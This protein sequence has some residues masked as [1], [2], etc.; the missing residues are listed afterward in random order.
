MKSF[1]FLLLAGSVRLSSTE[2]GYFWHL[3]DLHLDPNYTVTSDPRKVC[4]SAGDQLVTDAGQWGNYLCDSPRVLINS[5]IY[6]MKSILPKPDFILWTGDDTPHVPNEQLGEEAVL[7]I[8][9]WLTNLIQ[10]IFPT[11]KVYSALGNHDFH[12]KSQLPPHNNS[13]YYRISEFWSPWLKNESVISFQKGAYY[14]EELKDVGAAGRMIVLNTNLY[15]DSNSLTANMKDPG[16]Q[17][18]WLEEQLNN[19]YLKGE[20]VYIV[21]HVPP[22]YFEKKRDKPW[23]R[24]EFNKRFIEIIQK[25]HGVIQGQFFGHHH[26]D[27]FKMF[28][29]ESG[30]PISSMFIAPGV[31]PWK[32]T[33]PGVENGAN[34][35]GIRV[36]EYDRQNLQ[37][38]DIVTYYLNLTYANKV[39]PRWEKEYRLTEAFQVPDC[40]AQS[41]HSVLRKIADDSCYL[42]KYYEYNSVS[43]DLEACNKS[44]R[45]DHVCA[46][47]E[48]DFNKYKECIK[49][50]SSSIRHTFKII[51][52]FIA[53]S[54][55]LFTFDL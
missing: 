8:I 21:G 43:Y 45:A 7:E 52:L 35:P 46:I 25:H 50:E 51:V 54:V 19:A 9:K 26:T 28:Y 13:I 23:F 55:Y 5:S 44:C 49:T 42:Q 53:M 27:S 37:V 24:E 6:A 14:S 2:R 40:S 10:Q 11:T 18:Q 17:F 29:S 38:F 39:S 20:K 16:D 47:R 48:V 22:G 33:L 1:F 3:T 12:P 15:Y 36:V 34:N 32:T 30:T 4:P 31:T 41:M